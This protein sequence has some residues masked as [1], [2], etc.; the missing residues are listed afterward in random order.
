MLRNSHRLY[1]DATLQLKS[2]DGKMDETSRGLI[3][4]QLRTVTLKQTAA[5]AVT[6]ARDHIERSGIA[7]SAAAASDSKPFQ[8]MDAAVGFD[9]QNSDF[10]RALGNV[11]SK[12]D[13]FI[14]IIDKASQ[15]GI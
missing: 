15:V 13:V 10:L 2:T 4:V 14:G 1:A 3:T 7:D 9:P 6:D 5:D 11:L 8:A 12:L